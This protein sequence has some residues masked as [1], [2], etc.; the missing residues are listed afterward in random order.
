MLQLSRGHLYSFI[1]QDVITKRN[2]LMRIFDNG[3]FELHDC[4]VGKKVQ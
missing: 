4:I 1:S 3:M 2:H